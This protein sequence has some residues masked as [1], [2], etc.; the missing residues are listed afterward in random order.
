M[1]PPPPEAM[2]TRE[3]LLVVVALFTTHCP[4]T[5]DGIVYVT[6]ELIAPLMLKISFW[7]C[8]A[9]SVAEPDEALRLV[10]PPIAASMMD[11]SELTGT[12]QV[13]T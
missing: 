4:P 5:P 6:S 11:R 8:V 3:A 1:V 12:F 7:Y 13:L 10:V 2:I 9:V